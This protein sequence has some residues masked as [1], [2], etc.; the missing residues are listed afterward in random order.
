[1]SVLRIDTKWYEILLL[2]C[3]LP[4]MAA[5]SSDNNSDREEYILRINEYTISRDQIDSHLKLESELDSNFYSSS[6]TRSEFV[7]GLIQ[8]QLLI[9]EAKKQKFDQREPFRQAI[10]RYWES[11]L[12]R[13]LL[14]E[15][16][17]S[18]RKSTVVTKEELE[19]YYSENKEFLPNQ[20]FEEL[21]EELVERLTEK[22]VSERLTAWIQ[23]LQTEAD[24]EVV[25]QELA[26]SLKMQKNDG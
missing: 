18:I 16:G 11:T 14:D 6:E 24:I 26:A 25:D 5:C 4:S 12:I 9:Q 17:A 13:D 22:K 23:E 1:M 10:Q 21:Q 19:S 7:K 20:P 3:I 15:K 2:V 8:S